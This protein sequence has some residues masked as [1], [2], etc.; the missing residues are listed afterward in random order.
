MRLLLSQKQKL[1]LDLL[2]NP[3]LVDVLLGGG[4]GGSK[5]ITIGIWIVLQC[6]NF[7]GIRIGLG[8]KELTRL[9][10]TTVV[11]LLREVHPL[12]GVSDNEY[13]YNEQKAVITYVNGS[14]I[15]LVDLAWQPSDPDYDRFGSLNFTHTVIEEGGEV[16][17]KARDV[18]I[19]RKNRFM[20]GVY[21]IVGKSI[22][23][24]NPS[25][26]FLRQEYYKPYKKQGGGEHQ[27]WEHGRVEVNGIMLPA[28]RAFIRSLAKDNPFI[29]RNYIEVLRMLPDSERKRL[30]EGNWDYEDTDNMIF[31]PDI[32]DRSYTHTLQMGMR[33][34][35]VD[36]SDAGSDNTILSC[37]EENI[38][39]DQRK[40]EVDKNLAIGE[41]I[42]M[43]IIKYAQQNNVSKQNIGIDTIGVGASTRDFMRTKGWGVRE[44]VAGA[45]V[46]SVTFQNLRGETIWTM[47][48]SMDNGTLHIYDDLPTK[49]ILREE[50][51]AH[52]YSTEERVIKVKAKKE[53]K[54][55]LGRSPDYAESAY[56][57]FWTSQGINDP[58][59]NTSRI[60]Y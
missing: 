30:L 58:R 56:I 6:R 60:S 24:C 27:I 45:G 29:P 17:K 41:Q 48:Q 47:G 40:I 33:Y 44:F 55:D 52:E 25:Q 26:N 54:E 46:E 19:S 3:Q 15:Q 10:Q 18:F 35:G 5:S 42:A 21:H 13:I 43:A 2:D 51:M 34:V 39:W 31:K 7:P 11:T 57:A 12:L 16:K 1:T 8:R 37:I 14:S 53:I 28:Y 4:A 59:H 9:K 23:T 36:I 38:L 32:I 22:T 49:D 50:L 20:N